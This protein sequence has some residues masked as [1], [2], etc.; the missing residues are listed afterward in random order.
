MQTLH[1]EGLDAAIGLGEEKGHVA[2]IGQGQTAESMVD[3]PDGE[4]VLICQVSSPDD[5]VP[6]AL[7]GMV[8]PLTVRAA[9]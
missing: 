8:K 9:A 6:H 2:A 3:L 4:Y 7:K 1:E 5:G